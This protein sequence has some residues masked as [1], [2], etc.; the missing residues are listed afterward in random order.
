MDGTAA[1][2]T[3]TCTFATTHTLPGC[4]WTLESEGADKYVAITLAKKTMGHQS[5]TQLL[6]A[7]QVD[8]TITSRVFLQVKVADKLGTLVIG[9]FGNT[10]PE[11]VENFRALCT[12][13]TGTGDSGVPLHYKGSKFHRIM[14]GFMAQGGDIT[15]GDGTGGESIYGASFKVRWYTAGNVAMLSCAELV[16]L[17]PHMQQDDSLHPTLCIVAV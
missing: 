14:P 10:V 6:E 16:E 3:L 13:E 9:L 8:L 7:D 1:N 17:L 5:W 4:F 15:R 12:G 11:T 2:K